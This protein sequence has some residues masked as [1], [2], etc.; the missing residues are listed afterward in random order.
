MSRIVRPALAYGAAIFALGFVLGTIRTLW[1]APRIG[2]LAAVGV[3]LAPML[4][5]SWLAARGVLRRWPLA[6][7]GE[8]AA[9][10]ALALAVLMALECAL[11]VVAFGLT[12]RGW[13]GTLGSGPGLLGLAG[14]IG[15]A[16]MPGAVWRARQGARRGA[17]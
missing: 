4:G 16:A 5:A 17:H 13:A 15:F 3:E 12:L 8:A 9:M 6:R 7:R 11:G 14:Q 1:L 10:G 2:A